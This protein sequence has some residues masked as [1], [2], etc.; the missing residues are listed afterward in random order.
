MNRYGRL[1]MEHWQQVA[2]QRVAEL[3]DPTAFFS[4]LGQQV[5][6]RVQ[7]LQDQLAGPDVPG[8]D[9]LAKVGRLNMTRL[10]AE[11]MALAELVWLEASTDEPDPPSRTDEFLWAIHRAANEDDDQPTT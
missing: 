9:Y 10:Q 1:A 5:E 7:E 3:E 2:P 11:E 6:G 4:T 8:E